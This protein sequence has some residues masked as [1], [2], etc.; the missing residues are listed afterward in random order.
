M[1]QNMADR[2]DQRR[3]GHNKGACTHSSLEFHSE[4]SRKNHKH[5]HSAA[6]SDK[7]GA[8]TDGKAEEQGDSYPFS[9]KFFSFQS[10]FFPACIRLD[11]KA[12]TYEKCEEQSETSEYHI[13]GEK[14]YIAADRAHS[15]NAGEHDPPAL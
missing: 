5:H 6:R 1:D 12:N 15:E 3:E 10:L 14:S 2:G 7:A 8:E 13:S 9:V 4:K 11:Q